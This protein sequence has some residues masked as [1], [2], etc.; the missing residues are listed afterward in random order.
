MPA[1]M[2]SFEAEISGHVSRKVR[3]V[4]IEKGKTANVVFVLDLSSSTGI[5]GLIV[6]RA[7]KKAIPH[8]PI[9]IWKDKTRVSPLGM[10]SDKNGEI[11]IM[12]LSPGRYEIK[13]GNIL[14]SKA[15]VRQGRKTQVL[16][17]LNIT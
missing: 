12:G 15:V 1:G 17:K 5:K 13:H 9:S 4:Q 14:L 11:S 10:R 8:F 16:I 6:D 2:Y 7:K 3:H